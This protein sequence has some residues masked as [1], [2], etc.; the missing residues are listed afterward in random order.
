MSEHNTSIDVPVYSRRLLCSFNA[1]NEL[2]RIQW[3]VQQRLD[4]EKQVRNALKEP[5]WEV[6]RWR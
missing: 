1:N 5:I 6:L 3:Q 4:D 2:H